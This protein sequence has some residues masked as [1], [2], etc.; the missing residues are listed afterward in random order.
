LENKT[1]EEYNKEKQ[2]Y[3]ISGD[4]YLCLSLVEGCSYSLLDAMLTNLLIVSTDV[5]IM[6]NEVNKITFVD[7][8]WNNLDVN[9]ICNKIKYIWEN[10]KDYFNKSREAYFK[11]TSWDK[12]K[13]EWINI[14]NYDFLVQETNKSLTISPF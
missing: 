6:E 9:L 5:G 4:I 7:L 2:D 10:K 12:W 11:I 1:I 13:K 3:Y 14:L 8:S